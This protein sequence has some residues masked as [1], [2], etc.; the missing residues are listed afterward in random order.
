MTSST[1]S[2]SFSFFCSEYK[3]YLNSLQHPSTPKQAT[4]GKVQ[5]ALVEEGRHFS[6]MR[7]TRGSI[8]RYFHPE[9]WW[10]VYRNLRWY[11]YGMHHIGIRVLVL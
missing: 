4:I 10:R 11:W 6:K 1:Y 5:G 7:E 9:H 2:L 3:I 8:R